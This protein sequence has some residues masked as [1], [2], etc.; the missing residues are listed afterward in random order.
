MTTIGA[1][2]WK[3]LIYIRP[4]YFSDPTFLTRDIATIMHELLR[5]VTGKT[6]DQLQSNLGIAT[7]GPAA[8]GTYN[9]TLKL[10]A[11]CVIGH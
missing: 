3:T 11:D 7:S 5:A 10:M 2:L 1:P 6:D 4:E 8:M 9:I